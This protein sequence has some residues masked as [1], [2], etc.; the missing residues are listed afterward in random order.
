MYQ[1]MIYVA[2]NFIFNH[3]DLVKLKCMRA[4]LASENNSV[5]W[6]QEIFEAEVEVLQKGPMKCLKANI[7]I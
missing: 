5:L 2:L 6:R 1:S 4:G 3:N 7:S